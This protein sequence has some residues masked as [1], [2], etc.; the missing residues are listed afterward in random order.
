MLAD[1]DF[2]EKVCTQF[3]FKNTKSKKIDTIIFAK[4]DCIFELNFENKKI[5]T[6]YTYKE[7]LEK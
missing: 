1:I 7:D 3:Y 5:T 2:F 4:P 6:L